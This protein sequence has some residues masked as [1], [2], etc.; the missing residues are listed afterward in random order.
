MSQPIPAAL[1]DTDVLSAV[2]R[3]HS[4][5]MARARAYLAVHHRLTFSLVTR[6]E[7]LRGLYAK[8]AT[9]HLAAFDQLCGASIVLP[10]TDAI[11]VRAANIYADLQPRGSLI[12]DGD[13]LMAATA[14]EHSLV[15]ATNNASHFQRVAGIQLE[16]W[17]I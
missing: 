1:L 4:S 17:L 13:I 7:I 15:V 5:A 11:V 12:G 2:M 9:T 3:Q 10:L 6:Y 14:L 16:N 8:N